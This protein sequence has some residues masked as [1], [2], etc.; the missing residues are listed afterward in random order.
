[1]KDLS[2]EKTILPHV[3]FTELSSIEAKEGGS[4]LAANHAT[5]FLLA[6]SAF[7][8]AGIGM[9]VLSPYARMGFE[10]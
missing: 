6:A 9:A 7:S 10:A 8:D 2:H 4:I 3:V 1:M 5:V